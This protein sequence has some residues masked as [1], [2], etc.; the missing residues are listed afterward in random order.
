MADETA[1]LRVSSELLLSPRE[2]VSV[3]VCFY[4][5]GILDIF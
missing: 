3:C 1:F 5:K 4:L 2:R